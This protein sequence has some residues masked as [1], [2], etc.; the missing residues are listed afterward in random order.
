MNAA[1]K[2]TTVGTVC[3]ISI[4]LKLELYLF[5][6]YSICTLKYKGLS[7]F[8]TQIDRNLSLQKVDNHNEKG[9]LEEFQQ[10]QRERVSAF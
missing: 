7:K 1:P 8:H 3:Q 2:V 6:C 10:I 4:I 5:A 9:Q